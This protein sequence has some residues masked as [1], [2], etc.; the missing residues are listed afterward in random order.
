MQQ[1]YLTQ[2]DQ[3][4]AAKVRATIPG[5]AHW[6]GT[7]PRYKTC[8]ECEH[9]VSIKVGVGTSTRCEKYTLMMRGAQGTKKIPINT[10]ACKYFEERKP[11]KPAAP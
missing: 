7:G 8:G 11:A 5:M 4:L 9:W 1:D 6:A 10:T 3:D 2:P